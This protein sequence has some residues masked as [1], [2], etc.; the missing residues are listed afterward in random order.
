MIFSVVVLSFNSKRTIEKCLNSLISS[1]DEFKQPSEV[2]VID[3]GSIDGSVELIKDYA[4]TYP[5]IIKPTFFKEN[6][7]TTFS[8]NSGLKSSKGEY[9]LILDSDAYMTFSAL[10]VMKDYLDQSPKVGLVCPKLIY[11]D[12]R[13]QLSTDIFPTITR[14]FQRFLALDNIQKNVVESSLKTGKVDYA[15]SACWLIRRDAVNAVNGFDEA[16]FYAPED[17]DY[18]IQVWLNKFEI[19][20]LIDETVVHDAQELS[21]GFKI[22]KFHIEHVKGLL[23]LFKKYGYGFSARS[24]YKK[25][26]KIHHGV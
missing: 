17:V 21:R 5:D 14:K 18:C 20:Y 1:L 10:K 19:H 25:I 4:S 6:T 26:K 23:Y 7:G 12:G 13:F 8:R 11:G 3:N 24:L 16:I 2:F 22:T 9:V 15:I